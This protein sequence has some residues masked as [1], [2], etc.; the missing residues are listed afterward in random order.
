MFQKKI[1]DGSGITSRVATLVVGATVCLG[2]AACGGGGTG[3][4]AVRQTPG[5]HSINTSLGNAPMVTAALND[6]GGMTGIW[7]GNT[8]LEFSEAVAALAVRPGTRIGFTMQKGDIESQ[9]L[10][11]S[12]NSNTDV[13]KPL[14]YLRYG[15]WSRI[16][17]ETGGNAYGDHR[18]E[19]LGR[20]F[21]TG[22]DRARTRIAD[23]PVASTATYLGQFIGNAE[24]HSHGVVP[25]LGDAS[26]TVDFSNS[27]LTLEGTRRGTPFFAISGSIHGNTFSGRMF[28]QYGFEA[29][30]P[31]PGATASINGGFY[32]PQAREIGGVYE[33]AGTGTNFI[34]HIGAFGAIRDD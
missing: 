28:D 4:D 24:T 27:S 1:F 21:V 5:Y 11:S 3:G 17:P 19:S 22:R 12:W 15:V 34:R 30:P 14:A 32:G 13:L 23:M 33:I 10:V 18:Y 7:V 16:A 26:V 9:V 6:Q 29:A 25:V 2:L 31:A 20:G 8:K